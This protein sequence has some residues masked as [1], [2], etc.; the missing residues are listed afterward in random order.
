MPPKTT[1]KPVYNEHRR[2]VARLV[3][4]NKQA[5]KSGVYDHELPPTTKLI[6]DAAIGTTLTVA[7]AAEI[8]ASLPSLDS[9]FTPLWTMT[10]RNLYEGTITEA[11]GF[12]SNIIG[13]EP[14]LDLQ[15]I[16][17]DYLR[18][19][20]GVR[21]KGILEEDRR[22]MSAVLRT[23]AEK[24]K[25]FDEL[26]DDIKTRFPDYSDGRAGT[27]ARTEI[28]AA[29]GYASNSMVQEFAPGMQKRWVCMFNN[30]REDHMDAN[31]QTV[32]VDEQFDVGGESM[33]YPG[34]GSIPEN[35]IN[36]FS[37]DT[38]VL[39]ENGFKPFQDVTQEDMIATMNPDTFQIEYV[40]PLHKIKQRFKGE[41]V[42]IKARNTDLQVTK[43]HNV[44]VMKKEGIVVRPA[45]KL[46]QRDLLIRTAKWKGEDPEYLNL[47][48]EWFHAYTF[49]KFLGWYLSEGSATKIENRRKAY[50]YQIAIS[51][52]DDGARNEIA[53]LCRVFSQKVWVG[54]STVQLVNDELGEYLFALGHSYEKY[55]PS[56][57]KRLAPDYLEAFLGNYCKGDGS[58]VQHKPH[59]RI[60]RRFYTSSPQLASDI[61]EL[62]IKTGNYASFHYPK[63]KGR[64]VNF[65]NGA[66][67]IKHPAIWIIENDTKFSTYRES[68]KS[69]VDYDGFVYCV[70]MPRNHIIYTYRNGKCIWA[71]NCQCEVEYIPRGSE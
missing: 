55:I 24:G 60:I 23:D 12:V 26:V 41:L 4:R 20:G 52:K 18:E 64:V 14:A 7:A 2:V 29:D 43:D 63:L 61:G 49:M 19:Q 10:L 47:N 40:P 50:N 44:P 59:H 71:Q 35:N 70:E 69:Y 31:G 37:E 54:K 16:V 25:D 33:D 48:G 22:W 5:I 1:L 56:E 9:K 15:T 8:I 11:S 38:Q 68:M 53:E 42:Q 57:L 13:I 62:I 27:I 58:V 17:D 67:T 36:C 45:D 32:D 30:S 51:Q 46:I 3:D 39:T 65:R 34:G 6:R 28:H 21:I 66:Y